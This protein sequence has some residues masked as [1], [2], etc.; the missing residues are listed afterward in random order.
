MNAA[1]HLGEMSAAC[2]LDSICEKVLAG[3]RLN[4]EEGLQLFT[5][6]HVHVVGALANWVREKR[7]GD[8]TYFNRNLHSATNVCEADCIFVASLGEGWR[9]RRLHHDDATSCGTYRRIKA[10]LHF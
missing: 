4:A 5:T 3:E 7:H 8:I 1:V 9:R 2:G 10:N 6:P